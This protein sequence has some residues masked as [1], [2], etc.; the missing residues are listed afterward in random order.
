MADDYY[1]IL[2]VSKESSRTDIKKAYKKLAKKLHPD[3]SDTGD[4]DKFKKINEAAA[5]LGDDKKRQHYDQ[6]GTAEG[7]G[8]RGAGGF[9]F[10]GFSQQFGG[11][12]GDIFDHLG[13]I[14][15]GAFGFGGGG[16]R[17]R[18]QGN[19]LRY[20][21]DITLEEAAFGI[22]KKVDFAR[23]GKCPECGGS[24]AESDSDIVTCPDCNGA[25]RVQ[26]TQRT[27]FGLFQTTTAC[28]KCRGEG[29]AIKNECN[30]CDGTGLVREKKELDI[31]IPHGIDEGMRLR[32][33]GEGDAAPKGG[34][35]G[36]LYVFIHV[37]SHKYFTR[38]END[39]YLECPISISQAALGTQIEVP[40]LVGKAKLKIPAGTQPGTIF[41]MSGKGVQDLHG[42]SKGD[43]LVKA[44]VK[45]PKSSN[46]KQKKLFEDLE[47]E[48]EKSGFFKNLFKD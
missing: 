29:K 27:P 12:F 38:K 20:D 2:G 35:S 21:I 22:T 47:K 24:G 32:V 3:N 40:T 19:D 46:R 44:V 18:P 23:L 41:K 11:D 31:K 16:R 9:D 7:L 48:S 14:F 26:R 42:R 28:P 13:D 25:G 17:R 43:Q 45:V 4:A 15:G 39:I 1:D 36:D 5:V 6:F 34:V 8:G 33:G 10:N 30:K 37:L